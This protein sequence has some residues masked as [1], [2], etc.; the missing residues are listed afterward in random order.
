MYPEDVNPESGCRLRD[1]PGRSTAI[2]DP[3]DARPAPPCFG[4][5]LAGQFSKYRSLLA[6]PLLVGLELSAGQF[7]APV[8]YLPGLGG[9][10]DQSSTSFHSGCLGRA[11]E[12]ALTLRRLIRAQIGVAGFVAYRNDHPGAARDFCRRFFF[13]AFEA[14]VEAKPCPGFGKLG[15]TATIWHSVFSRL[16]RRISYLTI[17]PSRSSLS[18]GRDPPGQRAFRGSHV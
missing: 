15:S 11:L 14:V 17:Q 4:A 10:A 18:C 1:M 16:S 12:Q 6:Y 3:T 2:C 7:V 8:L 13:A 5:S 9:A